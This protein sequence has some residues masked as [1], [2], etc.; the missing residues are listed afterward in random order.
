MA[1]TNTSIEW[2]DR[3]WNPVRGC[4]RVS[5]GCQHC[6]AERVAYRFS[7]PGQPYEG[8]A[9]KV[10]SEPRWTG[11]IKL[12]GDAIDVPLSWQKPSRVFVN[13][14][15]DLFHE[16][17]PD[18]FLDEVFDVMAACKTQTFQLLTKRPERMATFVKSWYKRNRSHPDVTVPNLWLG[19]SVENQQTADE[20]I[21][22]LLRIPTAVRFLSCEPLLGPL[23]LTEYLAPINSSGIN[24]VICGGESGPGARPMHP[25][26]AKSLLAQCQANH[27]PFFF[28]QY[29]DW[30]PLAS[31][32]EADEADQYPKKR[33]LEADGLRWVRLGKKA[34][35]R[36][37]YGR[38]WNE[39]PGGV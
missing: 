10:G 13:S 30:Y 23:D 31:A 32:D 25:A 1:S 12:V 17:V 24:W 9:H 22:L 2:T 20:R 39:M 28:K 34:A 3:T 5:A 38:E 35:G 11:E 6:Y 14:M 19:V 33:L 16:K 37:L 21:P 29:G 36:L 4:T 7:G 18:D 27:V 15:S 8:L 26:W